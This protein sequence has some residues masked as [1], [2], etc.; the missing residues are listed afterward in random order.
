MIDFPSIIKEMISDKLRI[1]LTIL[2][3]AWGTAS[4]SGMLAIGQGLRVTFSHAMTGAGKGLLIVRPGQSSKKINGYGLGRPVYLR[5]SMLK[6]IRKRVPNLKAIVGEYQFNAPLYYQ[7]R[8]SVSQPYAVSPQ[9]AKLRS[10]RAQPGGR[11]INALDMKE[12]RRVIFIG[13]KVSQWLFKKG[14]NPIG[15]QVILGGWPFLIIGVMEPKMQFQMYMSPDSMNAWIPSTT[16]LSLSHVKSYSNWVVLPKSPKLV[17]HIESDIQGVVAQQSGLDP[18]DSQLL[19]FRDLNKRQEKTNDFFEN[20]Q[21]FLG[22]IGGITLVVA[23]VGIANVML[24]SVGRS[25]RQ[26]GIQIA[27]GAQRYH[28][29]SHYIL[30]ALLVT[31]VGG[32]LGLGFVQ[33][34]VWGLSKIPIKASIFNMLG[35]PQPQLSL[36]VVWVVITVLGA[37]GFLS[38]FFPA[39][40]AASIDP[41]LAL[42]H[43]A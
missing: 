2:A 43:D 19:Q 36:M 18:S 9:Y 41:A 20:M 22:L 6:T 7:G 16:F 10:I 8:L 5:P 23:G 35:K 30:E 17:A 40:K 15:R 37:V 29:L 4:I 31:V 42:R 21:W 39:K 12:K 28:I 24:V 3:I 11:F 13:N 38:G 33:F 26:I 32:V 34:I 27:L 14:E 25:Y 1:F